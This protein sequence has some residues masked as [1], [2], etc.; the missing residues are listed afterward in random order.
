MRNSLL[1]ANFWL[2]LAN[3]LGSF[4][5][6]RTDGEGVLVSRGWRSWWVQMWITKGS[7]HHS[8]ARD[9]WHI[10]SCLLW[11]GQVKTSGVAFFF[12]SLR[13]NKG[14]VLF[15]M[16][17][18]G[19]RLQHPSLMVQKAEL[20]LLPHPLAGVPGERLCTIPKK[21]LENNFPQCRWGAWTLNTLLDDEGRRD[22]KGYALALPPCSAVSHLVWS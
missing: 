14:I 10:N 12:F 18:W 19:T 16:N 4:R 13:K 22:R 11:N 3:D 20:S 9:N 1:K 7:P 2:V 17:A 21:R 15:W 5:C 8:N 6:A